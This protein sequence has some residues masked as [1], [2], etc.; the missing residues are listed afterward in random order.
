MWVPG[1]PLNI[2]DTK[3]RITC[4][5]SP[6]GSLFKLFGEES[7]SLFFNLQCKHQV[8]ALLIFFFFFLVVEE[9][10]SS[11]KKVN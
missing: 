3:A 10:K 4:P 7:F 2:L 9:S 6:L 1:S 8:V 5:N 11:L